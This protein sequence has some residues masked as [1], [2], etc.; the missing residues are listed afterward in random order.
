MEPYHGEL[1]HHRPFPI[2]LEQIWLIYSVLCSAIIGR[3][4]NVKPVKSN[5]NIKSFNESQ[6]DL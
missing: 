4:K 5:S 6:V 2:S 1:G 3:I